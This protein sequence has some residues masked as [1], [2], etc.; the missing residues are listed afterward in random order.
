[1]STC[2][3]HGV[4]HPTLKKKKIGNIEFDVYN[5][6]KHCRYIYNKFKINIVYKNISVLAKTSYNYITPSS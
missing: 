6:H 2:V 3:V 1:M 4:I 5:L